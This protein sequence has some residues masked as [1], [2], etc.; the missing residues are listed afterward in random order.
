MNSVSN[1]GN[2]EDALLKDS[3]NLS[4]NKLKNDDGQYPFFGAKGLLK[5]ISF[6]HQEKEYISIIKDGAGVGRVTIHP[7]KSSVVGTLQYLLPKEGYNIKFLFYYLLSVDF[8]KYI[9]GST[10]PHIYYKDYKSEPF[11]LFSIKEQKRIV[12][13][14][15]ESFE[16]IDKAIENTKKNI[17]NTKEL[18]Q[19]KLNEIFLNC[20]N[21]WIRDKLKEVTI[22][23]SGKTISKDIEKKVGEVL[24]VKVGDM[25]LEGNEYNINNSTRFVDLRDINQNQIILNGS[26]IFPKRG[27]AIA[28]NKKRKIVKPTIIDLNTMAV[29]PSNN[30]DSNYLFY[31]F[32]TIDLNKLSNGTSIPQI[33]NY[34]FD[35]IY[36]NY[37]KLISTQKEIVN[38]LD[39]LSDYTKNLESTYNQKL[40]D[41][42]ELKKSILDK[43]FK[44]EL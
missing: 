22:F 31:W 37:P 38:K 42:E 19:S 1:F 25:N 36:I 5:K 39:K 20:K 43:A 24:Y 16:K 10:I 35:D 15:D 2:L 8:S 3:S 29:S 6:Y 18:F 44:G 17:E 28:T 32:Q 27:G 4:L 26:V 21:N 41:L 30:L 40:L 13:K 33:N 12:K 34:S 7:P 11:P 23:K 14:I 9:T